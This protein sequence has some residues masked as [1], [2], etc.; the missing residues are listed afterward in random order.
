VRYF[1]PVA[2]LAVLLVGCGSSAS[3][4]GTPTPIPTSSYSD[5]HYKFSFKYPHV[6]SVPA[7]G[8]QTASNGSSSAYVLNVTVPGNV[9]QAS[10]EVDKDVVP[11]PPFQN[12]HRGTIQGD[13]HTYIYFHRKVGQWPAMRIERQLNGQTDEIDTIVNTRTLSY[14]ARL[15]TATPPFKQSSLNGY[16]AM[17]KSL[18]I[19]FS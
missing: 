13:P 9:A 12:G 19:P 11:F 5:P 17:V 6:W 3:G 4:N 16:A 1:I 10:V 7:K 8:G 15:I 18:K 14:D 2:A